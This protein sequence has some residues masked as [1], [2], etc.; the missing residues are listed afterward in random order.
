MTF[1]PSLAAISR[2]RAGLLSTKWCLRHRAV[3]R[4]PGP[5]Q[6]YRD[7]ELQQPAAPESF[8]DTVESPSL[9]SI[10][11]GRWCTERTWQCL[12]L[13]A[14]AEQ[15]VDGKECLAIR[16]AR[17]TSTRLQRLR[18]QQ[19]FDR[20]PQRFRWQV[21]RINIKFELRRLHGLRRSFELFGHSQT[22]SPMG[23]SDSLL[24]RPP[25]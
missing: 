13:N 20:A 23:F 8:E 22:A 21:S 2:V 25:R 19:R 24:V 9:E 7:V 18:R 4:L 6:P 5:A 11:Y 12:P 16:H 1:R 17:T 14:C 3:D 10:M 15:I